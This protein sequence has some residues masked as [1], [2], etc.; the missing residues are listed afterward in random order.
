MRQ[1]IRDH[2]LKPFL[3]REGD[4]FRRQ[5]KTM[6][7]WAGAFALAGLLFHLATS[8]VD[9]V[10]ED[11]LEN[12]RCMLQIIVGGNYTDSKECQYP[13]DKYLSLKDELNKTT[14][15]GFRERAQIESKLDCVIAIHVQSPDGFV[16]DNEI[17]ECEIASKGAGST[18][19]NNERDEE[20]QA[21]GES[22]SS[23]TKS[24]D[25]GSGANNPEPKPEDEGIIPDGWPLIGKLL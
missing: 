13:S 25:G 23:R 1:F 10:R 9:S 7:F 4:F 17:K 6:M 21:N 16:A 2:K 12:R 22:K 20:S 11:A 18:A 8:S 5:S 24:K 19:S 3:K 15:S 14:Q